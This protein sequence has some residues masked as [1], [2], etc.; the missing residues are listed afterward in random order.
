MNSFYENSFNP[1][2]PSV[3][4]IITMQVTLALTVALSGMAAAAEAWVEPTLPARV[5]RVVDGDTLLVRS[6]GQNFLIGLAGIDAPGICQSSG[7]LA[8]EVLTEL[9]VAAARRR[10]QIGI[11]G[12]DSS[13]R[14]IAR[15]ATPQQRDVS[16]AL[17]GLGAAWLHP[18]V[19]SDQALVDAESNA[20]H[21]GLGLWANP[22][23]QAPWDWRASGGTCHKPAVQQAAARAAPTPVALP[24]NK[25]FAEVNPKS[26]HWQTTDQAAAYA[27]RTAGLL[28][29]DMNQTKPSQRYP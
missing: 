23:A 21:N 22:R 29:Q 28:C 8:R 16:T 13:G 7:Y 18:K 17:V 10:I 12:W 26:G 9:V 15:V 5:L 3:R 11:I 1:L 19:D 25:P 2:Q 27:C 4:K 14:T 6:N 24:E 20:R